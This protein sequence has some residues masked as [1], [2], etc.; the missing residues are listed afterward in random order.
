[1]PGAAIGVVGLAIALSA[2]TVSAMAVA[3]A[4][5][6]IAMSVVSWAMQQTMYDDMPE[7]GGGKMVT[8]RD[9]QKPVPLIYGQR[10]IGLNQVYVA[11]S[12]TDNSLLHIIGV[13]G[14]G[15]IEGIAT[16]DDPGKSYNGMDS[17]WLDDKHYSEYGGCVSYT[18]YKG[19]TTQGV[20]SGLPAEWADALR[21]TAYLHVQLYYN[22]NYFS[23][24]PDI[25][26]EIKGLKI[27][28][29]RDSTIK[30]TNNPALENPV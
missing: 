18:L 28:D 13:I 20:A 26:V 7:Q 6:Q 22:Q 14:E 19:T 4:I 16:V 8:A 25:T 11:S 1:M 17:V 27:L 15:E 5:A 10:R 12:G 21:N 29:T 2:N 9:P 30:Y 3:A 23:N 24:L